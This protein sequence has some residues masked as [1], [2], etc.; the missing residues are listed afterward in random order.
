MMLSTERFHK[1]YIIEAMFD[2]LYAD[3]C[4]SFHYLSFTVAEH[5]HCTQGHHTMGEFLDVL[6]TDL[7]ADHSSTC[8][9]L[10]VGRSL[11]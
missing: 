9:I 4:L 8:Y 10:N 7:E 11:I 3:S 5:L 6:T 2:E 1:I